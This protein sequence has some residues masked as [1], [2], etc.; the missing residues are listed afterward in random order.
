[1]QAEASEIKSVASQIKAHFLENPQA[2]ETLE[3]IVRWWLLRQQF[4]KAWTT[5]SSA[6]NE[7]VEQGFLR[8]IKNPGGKVVYSLARNEK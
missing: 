2:A 8:R 1:M 3:G 6:L 5:V 4:N 7:L